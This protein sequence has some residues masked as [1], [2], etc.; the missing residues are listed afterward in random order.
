MDDRYELCE[1]IGQ[2]GI[3]SVYRAYDQNLGREVAIKR[4]LTSEDDPSLK[5]EATKQ[6]MVEAQALASL[7]HP[8]IVMI[9]DVGS[10]EEGPYVVME[11]INGKTLDEM[12]ES[13]P[14]SWDDCKQV[15]MQSLE[16]LIAAEEL[17]MIHSDLKPPNI[18]LTWLASGSFQVKVLDFGLAVL[19]HKQSQEEIEKMESMFGSIFFMPPEQF[20]RKVLDA[21]SDLYSLGCCFYQALTGT[22]PYRG[23][24]GE[25]VMASHLNHTVIP[26]DEVRGGIPIWACQWIMWLINRNPDDRPESARDA[27]AN[28]IQNDSL[29]NHEMSLG[30]EPAYAPSPPESM[31]F[32]ETSAA[33]AQAHGVEGE[34][35]PH[36]PE[37]QRKSVRPKLSKL[38]LKIA[39]V[40]ASLL[41]LGSLVW[42]L[43]QRNE[44]V[45]RENTYNYI[46]SMAAADHVR[47][48]QIS[49]DHL[50]II[51][52]FI[53][54]SKP[55]ADLSSAYRALVIAK[56]SDT[57]KIDSKIAE[58]ATSDGV[59]GSIRKKL[60][61]EVIKERGDVTSV[62]ALIRFS[63]SAKNPEEAVAAIDA[64]GRMVRDTH[65]EELLG[66]L[67]STSQPKV[68]D[69]AE[70]LLMTI[71]RRSG[72]RDSLAQ[73]IS[74]K[75][76]SDGN[77]SSREAMNRLIEFATPKPQPTNKP[78]PTPAPAPK[79]Q[80]NPPS[81]SQP[82]P[83]KELQA[84]TEAINGN[85]EAKKIEAITALGN[86]SNAEAHLIL[87]HFANNPK[88]AK[89]KLKALQAVTRL[90][91]SPA[92]V[93]AG[94]L[95]RQRWVRITWVAKTPEEEKLVID[96]VSNIR[97]D[98][99]K[100]I[101]EA[102]A[103]SNRSPATRELAQKALQGM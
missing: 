47:E 8:N 70:A 92:L 31:A 54:D 73:I 94:D 64:I 21:R 23:E 98:W 93:G 44:R 45:Q 32:A 96:A 59:D 22:Y 52:E 51:L 17:N 103:Q 37:A 74:S 62:L 7:Q 48:V 82:A 91:S 19:I 18:M 68:R 66:V 97:K 15:A 6:L 83:P 76:K 63:A 57:T 36:A 95:A 56:A 10:D 77:Q 1:K 72:N 38:Y 99:V 79:P 75:G 61:I 58:F 85:D 35:L 101:L 34:A 33:Q 46:V 43:M 88:N 87:L 84:Y 55:N 102:M 89:L 26:I 49:G 81:N 11:M 12:I 5:E 14:L 86:S 53:R 60:F 69:A 16:A 13:A 42:M 90:N 28:F 30:G 20:E 24:S 65:F 78:S 25:E 27:L 2:G 3:G 29:P 4:I 40:A 50:Q 9:Q 71:I 39:A 80:S 41:L 100:G 67:S